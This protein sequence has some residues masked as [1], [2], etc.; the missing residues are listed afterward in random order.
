MYTKSYTCCSARPLHIVH[1]SYYIKLQ[2]A[3]N[4]CV[5]ILQGLSGEKSPLICSIIIMFN[6]ELG[7]R[8]NEDMTLPTFAS[9]L[10]TYTAKMSRLFF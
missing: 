5:N 4:N 6:G 1:S 7:L 3:V 9:F 10:S 2:A 8:E